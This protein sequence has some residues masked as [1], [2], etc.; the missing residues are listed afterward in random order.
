MWDGAEHETY[1]EHMVSENFSETL[2][3]LY[4]FFAHCT[5]NNISLDEVWAWG[6]ETAY[7]AFSVIIKAD[8]CELE[9]TVGGSS[10]HLTRINYI[11]LCTELVEFVKLEVKSWFC[12][13]DDRGQASE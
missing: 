5:P 3:S 4:M 2:L 6:C 12:N 9:R 10:R 13:S 8:N 1:T 11:N 7:A